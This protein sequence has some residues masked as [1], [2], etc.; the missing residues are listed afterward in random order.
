MKSYKSYEV[1]DLF[2]LIIQTIQHAWVCVHA[3][4]VKHFYSAGYMYPLYSTKLWRAVENFARSL[5]KNILAVV[6]Q[7]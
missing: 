7:L 5:P 3:R 4:N 6:D 2:I 1:T